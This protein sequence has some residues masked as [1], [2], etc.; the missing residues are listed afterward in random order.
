MECLPLE[1]SGEIKVFISDDRHQDRDLDFNGKM[2]HWFVLTNENVVFNAVCY[3]EI[4]LIE[5]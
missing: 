2:F 5:R 3:A 4:M 1:L